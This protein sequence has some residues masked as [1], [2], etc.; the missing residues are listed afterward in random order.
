[1]PF[2]YLQIG[3]AA[4]VGWWL[5]GHRPD[6]WGWVGMAVIALSGATSAWLNLR[7]ATPRLSPVAADTIA[8]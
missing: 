4:L 2:V 6:F 7:G 1:M 3:A 5:F 8:D